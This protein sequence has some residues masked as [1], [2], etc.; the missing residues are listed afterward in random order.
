MTAA[1]A[2]EEIM[3]WPKAR[4]KARVRRPATRIMVPKDGSDGAFH[5]DCAS[6]IPD[7][8]SVILPP[9]TQTVPAARVALMRLQCDTC[10]ISFGWP[11]VEKESR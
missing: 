2:L 1:T 4:G 8:R 5:T 9:W 10:G 3:A 7:L 6:G 11:E